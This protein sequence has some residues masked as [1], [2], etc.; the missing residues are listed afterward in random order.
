MELISIASQARP[1]VVLLANRG[2]QYAE[3]SSKNKMGEQLA[4][5]ALDLREI[6]FFSSKYYV[7]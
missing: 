7:L 5:L 1:R 6:Y 2:T 3:H 4:A